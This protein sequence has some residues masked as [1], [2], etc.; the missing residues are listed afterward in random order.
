MKRS[1]LE[2]TDQFQRAFDL[3]EHSGRNLFITGRA[4]TGKSTL[5]DYYRTR[6][7]KKI[8]V[9]A[10]TGVAALNVRGQTIHSFF[11]FK[12]NVTVQ[13]I[14]QTVRRTDKESIYKQLDMIVIDEISMVR[15]DLLDCIDRF[16]RLNGRSLQLPFGGT[17][18]VFIGDLYQLP[19][20]MTR[21]EKE[22]FRMVYKSPYFF[23]A[24][25]FTGLEMEIVEL[26]KVFRQ[27]DSIFINILN[28][29]RNNSVTSDNLAA[30][31]S[32][33]NTD[34]TDE[35]DGFAITLT[36]TNDL[37][38]EINAEH[39]GMIAEKMHLFTG[40][41]DGEVDTKS[42]PTAIDLYLKVGAQVMLLNND[43][44]GQWVNGSVGKIIGIETDIGEDNGKPVE[45]IHVE[46]SE[47][48]IVEVSPHT[49]EIFHYVFDSHNKM[50]QS[51]VVGSFTQYPLRLAWAVT[52]HKSQGKT[53]DRVIIDV[54]RGTFSHGQMYVAL[55]RC[56][57]LDGLVLKKTFTKKQILL[58]WRVVRF[59]T[60]SQYRLSEER[61]PLEEKIKLIED[62]IE[63]GLALDVVYLKTDD[64]RTRRTLIPRAIGEMEYRNKKYLGMEAYCMLRRE[65]RVFRVD[66][67]LEIGEARIDRDYL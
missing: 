35:D 1:P 39:L 30:L 61:Y 15:A 22:L 5:L 18:M 28:A 13:K 50:I 31:N 40:R 8:V 6:T 62:A 55:S 48:D 33:Y 58:D 20:V 36:T 32:R 64:T 10:P 11:R 9:L 46:L 54:G 47:G 4:G 25:S 66:R 29:I 21:Y 24:L 63:N 7:K 23:D 53:F 38:D 42:L 67:I 57:S 16:M 14:K 49:W 56:T 43:S 27:K 41:L 26:D 44:Y 3:L 45:I 19:P 2:I 12:P 59:L 65:E 60:G 17:R 52:I 37:A 51:K 34:F